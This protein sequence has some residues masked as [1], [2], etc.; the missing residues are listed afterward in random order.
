MMG[1][2]LAGEGEEPERSE[3][4]FGYGDG[5]REGAMQSVR[6]LFWRAVR[7]SH[8]GSGESGSRIHRHRI[9]PLRR[10]VTWIYIEI[11]LN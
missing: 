5:R 8:T 4:V 9:S 2:K 3:K 1:E 10:H 6:A 11:D 7:E